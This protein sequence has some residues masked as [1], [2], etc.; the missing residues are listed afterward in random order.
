M[1]SRLDY[2][3]QLSD[4]PTICRGSRQVVIALFRALVILH[5]RILDRARII[6]AIGLYKLVE[7]SSSKYNGDVIS[8][9]KYRF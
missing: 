6:E 3:T 1:V 2:T 4:S 8:T 9:S 5:V 7:T